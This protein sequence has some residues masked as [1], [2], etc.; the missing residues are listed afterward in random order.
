MYN[1]IYY[2]YKRMKYA[3]ILATL[4]T[5]AEERKKDTKNLEKPIDKSKVLCYN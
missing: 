4:D 2:M 1:D 3:H 5:I